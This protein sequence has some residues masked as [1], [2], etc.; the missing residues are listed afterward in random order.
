MNPGNINGQQG[1]A[2][3]TS[4]LLLVALSVLGFAAVNISNV[5][6]RITSNT[7]TSKQAFY[8]AEAGIEAAREL[9]RTRMAGG[10]TLSNELNSVKGTN[11]S[12]VDSSNVAN[13]STTGNT[14][15]INTTS[16]G[17]GNYKVYLTNDPVDG[18]TSITDTNGIVTLTSF[19][20]GPDNARAVIQAT[21]QKNGGVPDLPGAITMPGPHVTFAGGASNASSYSG[22]ATHPA[23]VVNS[24]ASQTETI[25]GIPSNRLNNYTGGGIGPPSVQNMTIPDPWANLSKMQA[26]YNNLK[27][28]A[29]YSSPTAPGFTLGTSSNRKVVVIDG[30]YTL[31]GGGPAA[32]AYWSLP[33][34]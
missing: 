33:E 17:K 9:L 13:F 24:A 23:I 34:T 2:L 28:I 10:N 32:P 11:G 15:Y 26:L 8:I 6:T 12:L 18:L 22:D 20:A 30:D 7:Q 31:G 19:G 14:P 3:L 21:I 25:G 27:G 16:F 29:D 1:I 5:G 4:I